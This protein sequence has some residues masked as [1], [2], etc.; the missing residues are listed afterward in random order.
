MCV[1][2]CVLQHVT[3]R[4]MSTAPLPPPPHPPDEAVHVAVHRVVRGACQCPLLKLDA[5][6]AHPQPPSQSRALRGP[7]LKTSSTPNITCASF[8]FSLFHSC[9]QQQHDKL[10]STRGGEVGGGR[11]VSVEVWGCGWG[12][13]A[14]THIMPT[15]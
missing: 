8:W 10:V 5:I 13:G 12:R 15:R 14:G 4:L 1:C 6:P 3:Q 9:G 2:H 11:G 7:R